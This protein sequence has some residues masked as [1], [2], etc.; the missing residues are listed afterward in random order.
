MIQKSLNIVNKDIIITYVSK[1]I[2]KWKSKIIGT[3]VN[4]PH[5]S[6]F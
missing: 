4:A 2:V 5:M 3:E 1:H 6:G